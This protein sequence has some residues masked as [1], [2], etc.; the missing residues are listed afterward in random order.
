MKKRVAFKVMKITAN[1][2][3]GRFETVTANLI[4]IRRKITAKKKPMRPT[5]PENEL[6]TP[7][8]VKLYAPHLPE[9]GTF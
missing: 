4:L 3:T 5:L 8:K 9:N 6:T 7:P 2:K 1:I